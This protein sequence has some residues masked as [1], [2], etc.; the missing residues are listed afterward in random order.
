MPFLPELGDALT[1]T[2]GCDKTLGQCAAKFANSE[3]FR[4]F[5]HIPGNDFALGYASTLEIMDGGAIFP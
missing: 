2:A 5:P 3:R 1:V 4:G